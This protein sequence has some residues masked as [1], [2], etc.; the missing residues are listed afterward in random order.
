M[1][2]K[3]KMI[4]GENEY[5]ILNFEYEMSQ[6][7]DRNGVPR[8]S[9]IGNLMIITLEATSRNSEIT[10]WAT[11]NNM[12][13]TGRVEFY[14]R[15]GDAAGK[16]IKFADAYLIY[17]KDVFEANGDIPMKTILKISGM[18]V[19]VDDSYSIVSS[20]FDW[21]KAG[22]NFGKAAATAAAGMLVHTAKA[23]TGK[24][25]GEDEHAK[26]YADKGFDSAGEAGDSAISSF[27]P[28]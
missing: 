15:D 28:D 18:N 21:K 23:E 8:A 14:R 2:F 19:T 11:D 12:K 9:V 20:G 27:I 17:H 24:A 4:L 1:S 13:K 5:T 25:L 16:T 26:G 3:A 10:E 6:A 7:I 22:I